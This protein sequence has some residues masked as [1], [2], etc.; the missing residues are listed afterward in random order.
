LKQTGSGAARVRRGFL[1]ES[2]PENEDVGIGDLLGVD[3]GADIR[4][5]ITAK[6]AG[7]VADCRAKGFGTLAPPPSPRAFGKTV[8]GGRRRPPAVADGREPSALTRPQDQTGK[9][10][11][12][13]RGKGHATS[14]HGRISLAIGGIPCTAGA[15]E[16]GEGTY[17]GRPIVLSVQRGDSEGS[18]GGGGARSFCTDWSAGSGKPFPHWGR[19]PSRS[20][21][22]RTGGCKRAVFYWF[23]WTGT[24]EHWQLGARHIPP[25]RHPQPDFRPHQLGVASN[26]NKLCARGKIGALRPC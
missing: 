9:S 10:G 6:A 14:I 22:A 2:A 21:R 1:A 4:T 11:V 16:G 19:G 18:E 24:A 12:I 3:R 17:G 15:G 13:R 25:R 20:G 7:V 8:S 23:F 26:P 5:S